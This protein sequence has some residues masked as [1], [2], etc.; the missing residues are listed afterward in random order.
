M[1]NHA[2]IPLL[3]FDRTHGMINILSLK[4]C[5]HYNPCELNNFESAT[6]Y[7]ITLT[8]LLKDITNGDDI[9]HDTEYKR[10]SFQK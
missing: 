7:R 3:H 9:N 6:D 8:I 2:T 1:L 4:N 5:T 10:I